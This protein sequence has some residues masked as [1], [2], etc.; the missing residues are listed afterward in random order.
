[1]RILACVVAAMA[2]SGVGSAQAAWSEYPYKDLGFIVRFPD[3]PEASSG[4]YKTLLVD[5]APV[6]IF[7]QKLDN[8]LFIASVADLQN[9]SGDGASLMTEAEFNLTLLGD[10][11][12]N[13]ISR[14]ETG[15]DAVFGR[16]ITID[17]KKGRVPA[18][19]GQDADAQNW[20]KGTAG[21]DCPDGSRLTVNLF[22]NRGRIYMINGINLPTNGGTSA[23]PAA[24]RFANSISFFR[25]DGTRSASDDVR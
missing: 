7:T 15:K 17:C 21:T 19:P 14:V 24:L 13:S 23:G 4:N 11:K 3:P 10:I 1:M 25:A 6:H 22:F 5:A 8:A 12:D 20:F 16:F 2:F 18:Q 9:R